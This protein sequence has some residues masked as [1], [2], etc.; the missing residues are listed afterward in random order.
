MK[1]TKKSIGIWCNFV[2]DGWKPTDAF[3]RGT[4]QFVKQFAEESVRRGYV[5]TVFQNGFSGMHNGCAYLTHD[6]FSPNVV[7]DVFLIVKDA[8]A[9]SLPIQAKRVFYYTN[10]IDDE[11]RLLDRDRYKRAEKVFALSSYH[12]SFFLSKIPNVFILSHGIQKG[13][14]NTE[15]HPFFCVYASSPDRGLQFLLSRWEEIMREIPEARLEVCYNGKTQEEM[16]KIYQRADYWVY[17]CLG[18]ELYCVAGIYAQYYGCVPVV[19]PTMALKETVRHGVFTTVD[20]FVKDVIT[21]MKD[22]EKTEHI[23][24]LLFQEHFPSVQDEWEQIMLK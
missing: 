15:K 5:V 1:T 3:L 18:V 19:F 11:E 4:E 7:Y 21:I 14:R 22:R 2:D 10:D 16:E 12:R 6:F 23:R 24:S 9:L 13:E 20:S 8:K 17:P